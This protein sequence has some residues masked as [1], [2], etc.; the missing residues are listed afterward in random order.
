MSVNGYREK[1][2]KT[3]ISPSGDEFVIRRP[4]RDSYVKLLDAQALRDQ[5]PAVTDSEDGTPPE[6][7]PDSTKTVSAMMDLMDEVIIFCVVSPKIAQTASGEALAIDELEIFDYFFLVKEIFEFADLSEKKMKGLF[8]DS[9]KQA[10]NPG[11][12]N[13]DSSKSEAKPDTPTGGSVG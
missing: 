8:Q 4:G 12:E 5:I 2:R 13:S 9:E 6:I 1:R 10:G 3:L 11:G 7:T